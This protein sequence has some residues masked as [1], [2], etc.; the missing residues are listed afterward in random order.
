MQAVDLIVYDTYCDRSCVRQI[1]IV[2][3]RYC[4]RLSLPEILQNCTE[5]AATCQRE[6]VFC[7]IF[8]CKL[9]CI[10]HFSFYFVCIF[11]IFCYILKIL[12]IARRQ[13]QHVRGRMFLYF[14]FLVVICFT[15]SKYCKLHGGRGNVLEEECINRELGDDV[16][17]HTILQFLRNFLF[18]GHEY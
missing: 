10:L 15:L 1:V 6:N 16:L 14:V 13:R 8:R 18:R 3:D 9:Y 12:Q 2:K 17:L 5:P 7:C 11:G 4:V